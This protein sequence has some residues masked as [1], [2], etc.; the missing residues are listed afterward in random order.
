[1]VGDGYLAFESAHT[2]MEMISGLSE[3]MPDV[4]RN[5]VTVL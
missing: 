5:L 1:M 3:Q 2:N 4:I